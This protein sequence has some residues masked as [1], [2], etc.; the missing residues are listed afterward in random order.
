[1]LSTRRNG[2]TSLIWPP[3]MG[4]ITLFYCCCQALPPDRRHPAHDA[5]GKT[6]S[7]DDLGRAEVVV[8]LVNVRRP[9]HEHL[10]RRQFEE[11]TMDPAQV[12]AR[13]PAPVGIEHVR[14]IAANQ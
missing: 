9:L 13:H 12:G 2:M 8:L 14:G 11:D 5:L 10:G 1:M 7:G 4:S 3:A 6:L